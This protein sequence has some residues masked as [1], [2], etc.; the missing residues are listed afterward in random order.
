MSDFIDRLKE[1]H[2]QLI[3]TLMAANR[4]GI[5]SA[6]GRELLMQAQQAFN[7]HLQKEDNGL[8]P[9]LHRGSKNNPKL[10]YLLDEFATEMTQATKMVHDFYE[11][12][13]RNTD[14]IQ[15]ATSFGALCQ[16]LSKR[17]KREENIL[18]EE[19]EKLKTPGVL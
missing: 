19:Y 18:Y 7:L 15:L 11:Q 14:E 3:E 8:Y 13:D 6:A 17:I 16:S 2:V 9:L 5:T 12:L 4:A 10:D 1:D